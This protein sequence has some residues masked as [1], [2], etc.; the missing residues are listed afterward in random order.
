MFAMSKHLSICAL[1]LV[2]T[3]V[4]ESADWPRFLG[5]T[6]A[7]VV[8]ESG[9]PTHW[10]ATE[11]LAWKFDMPGPGSSSPIVVGDKVFVTCWTGYGDK[12]GNDDMSRLERHLVCLSLTDGRKLWQATV[13]SKV[14][15]DDYQGFITEH[16]YA[17]ST[18]VSDGQSIYV[19]FGKTGAAA[20]DMSGKQLWLTPL[21][22]G[23]SDRRWGSGGSPVLYKDSL[24]VNATD[25]CK[26]LVAL[27]KK[28][29]RELWR[30]GGD[31]IELAYST[32]S[33][34]ETNGRT[35]LV[36]PIAQEI[37]GLNP[38]TGKLRW[39]ATHGLPG[40]VSPVLIQ[41]GDAVY[42]FGGYPTQGSAAVRLGGKGDVTA[43]HILWQSK[44][45]SY[46]PT[47]VLHE[48]HLYV[49]NDAGFALCMEAKTGRDVYR[50]RV[51]ESGGGRGRGGKPFYASPV[52]IGDRIYAV[53]RRN[54][55]FILAARPAF[56][57]LGVVPPLDD[58]QFHGTPAV[59]GGKML[60]RSDKS[61][62]CIGR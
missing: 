6:G 61:V 31:M 30:A 42:L 15:E 22:N 52:L 14:R 19:F 7:A 24:I 16:G 23:S 1:L 44:S 47:P 20:F 57:K 41:D 37:W 10:S 48:D 27:D 58:S 25:E 32:P 55:T 54:G 49:V 17:T 33:I 18:P 3:S 13:P 35:D 2:L 40:N 56:E 38:E 28:T 43:S 21:G 46:V 53:S 50:E 36:F 45:S 59:V 34:L 11:N 29:G 8:P 12:P 51:M 4:A 5:P 9:I 39:Y 60:L 62:Y 26:S